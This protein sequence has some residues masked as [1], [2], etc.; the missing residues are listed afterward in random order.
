MTKNRKRPTS[1]GMFLIELIL[2]ILIF[3]IVS[4][5]CVQFFMKSYRQSQEA[6]QLS[7]ASTKAAAVGEI[8]SAS[9]SDEEAKMLINRAFDGA[10]TDGDVARLY[11]DKE[12]KNCGEDEAVYTV[13]VVIDDEESA[14]SGRD[15]FA[16]ILVNSTSTNEEIYSLFVKHHTA[17]GR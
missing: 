7:F 14:S 12:F 10:D 11:F 4:A 17:G 5:I 8:I 2:S 13:I 9:D 3:A 16:N 1:S 6:K 15:I